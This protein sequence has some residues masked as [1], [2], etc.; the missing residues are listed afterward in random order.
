MSV[1][2]L[3]NAIQALATEER[4]RLARWFDEHRHELL[5]PSEGDQTLDISTAQ[6]NEVLIRRAEA[7]SDPSCLESFEETISTK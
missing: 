7:N 6:Q 2:Q 1:E 5:P 3:E 4:R